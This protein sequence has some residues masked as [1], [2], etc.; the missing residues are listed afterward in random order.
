MR[1]EAAKIKGKSAPDAMKTAVAS[2]CGAGLRVETESHKDAR[3]RE[4]VTHVV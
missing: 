3:V 4:N 2:K 1:R